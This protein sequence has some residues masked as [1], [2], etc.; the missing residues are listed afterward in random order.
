[1]LTRALFDAMDVTQDKA[2]CRAEIEA[3]VRELMRDSEHET[4]SDC[5]VIGLAKKLAREL[6]ENET[7]TLQEFERRT[8]LAYEG[9]QCNESDFANEEPFP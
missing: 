8:A 5:V 7:I 3:G 9:L 2:L 1:M 6:G 4:Q